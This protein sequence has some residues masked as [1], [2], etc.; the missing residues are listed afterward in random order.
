MRKRMTKRHSQANVFIIIQTW[1]QPKHLLTGTWTV[2]MYKYV[3][4][5]TEYISAHN[6]SALPNNKLT[7]KKAHKS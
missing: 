4:E 3:Y 1:K 7:Q 2:K 5:K 6:I